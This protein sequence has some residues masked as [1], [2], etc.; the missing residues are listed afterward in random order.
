MI[1]AVIFGVFL[2]VTVVPVVPVSVLVVGLVIIRSLSDYGIS[3]GTRPAILSAVSLA[4]SFVAIYALVLHASRWQGHRRWGAVA[5]L[6][7]GAIALWTLVG[8]FHYGINLDLLIDSV[9]ILSAAAVFVL[10]YAYAEVPE[11]RTAVIWMVGPAALL[12]VIGGLASLEGFVNRF[13]RLAGTFSHPNAAAAFYGIAL[14]A[15]LSL[16]LKSRTKLLAAVGLLSF[17]ALLLTGS[18][19]GIAGT[20]AGILLLVWSRRASWPMRRIIQTVGVLGSLV[21]A[22]FLT[23]LSDRIAEFSF[24][25]AVTI[26]S[27]DPDSFQWRIENW[28][29]LVVEWRENPILGF[30]LGASNH[31]VMPLGGPPHSLYFQTLV[32]MGII[33]ILALAVIFVYWW[34][35][36]RRNANGDGWEGPTLVGLFGFVFVNGIVSNFLGYM[37]ALYLTVALVGFLL[38]GRGFRNYDSTSN[39]RPANLVSTSPGAAE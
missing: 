15:V 28:R 11:P 16:W 13:G 14:I 31:E 25:G 19:G 36:A 35:K 27:S 37:A 22:Y 1:I 26:S 2:C 23:G 33:G 3:T 20:V 10:A 17:V 5:Q 39:A 24:G 38:A 21:V 12:G 4:V 30:G 7:L 6:M 18:L 9:R 8:I 34:R 32:D 29:R